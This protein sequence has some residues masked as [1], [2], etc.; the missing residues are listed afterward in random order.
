MGLR[1]S[2]VG[3]AAK[4]LRN[5]AY[6]GGDRNAAATARRAAGGQKLARVR[7][8]G[9]D[10]AA[11]PCCVA[12][13]PW[14]GASSLSSARRGSCLGTKGASTAAILTGA[15]TPAVATI[16]SSLLTPPT[17]A[18][19]SYWWNLTTA[20]LDAKLTLG[21]RDPPPDGTSQLVELPA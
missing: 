12:G 7:V 9:C 14:A 8:S 15:C 18:G 17:L 21:T 3:D 6:L 4:E 5:E 10:W 1:P 20:A 19:A 2:S 13:L 11:V 16:T